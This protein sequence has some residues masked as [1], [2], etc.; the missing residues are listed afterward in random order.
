[1][2]HYYTGIYTHTTPII[3]QQDAQGKDKLLTANVGDARVLLV[4]DGQVLQLTED[5]VPD[6]YEGQFCLYTFVLSIYTPKTFSVS[7]HMH[8]SYS[9][10]HPPSPSHIAPQSPSHIASH[11]EE[12]RN[13][14]ESTN[15]NRKMPLVRYVGRTWRVGGLLA[16]SRAFGDAYMKSD[17]QYNGLAA[18]EGDGYG[19]GFGVVAVPYTQVTELTDKDSWLIV[20]SDG[21]FANEERGGGS[22]LENEE[23]AGMLSKV[24]KDANLDEA[25]FRLAEAAVERGSTDDVTV[26][27]LRLS[28]PPAAAA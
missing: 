3:A 1:M 8:T 19:S 14:I 18:D 15:P 5:H 2:Q 7:L 6:K 20:C 24:G 16:L 4:R 25:A 26:T 12:E 28:L 17:L 27:L 9:V 10:P 21:L 23:L 11:S 13:R 22:G